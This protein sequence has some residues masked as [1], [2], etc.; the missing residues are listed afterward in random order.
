MEK[1]SLNPHLG[2]IAYAGG[3]YAYDRNLS[4]RT[5][6][7]LRTRRIEREI[8]EKIVRLRKSAFLSAAKTKEEI[9][10]FL[11]RKNSGKSDNSILFENKFLIKHVSSSEKAQKKMVGHFNKQFGDNQIVTNENMRFFVEE[12]QYYYFQDGNFFNLPNE[13]DPRACEVGILGLP[14]AT[15][16]ASLGTDA[17]PR[18]LRTYSRSW[19]W[20][21]V[22]RD[23]VYQEVSLSGELPEVFCQ[24][25]N[26][27]DF[28]DLDFRGKTVQ[29][30]FADI[31]DALQRCFF[32]NQVV[33]L[34]FGGDHAVTYPL[35]RAFLK[36]EPRL[37][38]L[39]LDAH[40]DLFYAKKVMFNH[41]TPISNLMM[42]T[43]LE[44]VL[45]FGLRTFTG[46]RAAILKKALERDDLARRMRL[47]SITT[48]KQMIMKPETLRAE[49]GRYAG[50]PFFLT[51]DL[52]VLSAN[53]IGAQL[54]TPFGVGLEWHE[55]FYFLKIA[56]EELNI[57][58]CDI[59]EYNPA[60][61]GHVPQAEYFLN[62]LIMLIIDQLAK[63]NP[64]P[65]AMRT[66]EEPEPL[67][68]AR[69]A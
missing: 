17:A 52:D 7:P 16:F 61:G 1:F 15:V 5:H 44:R 63:G 20:F 6:G 50:R 25:V 18:L 19:N 68:E 42:G 10:Q 24:G 65:T 38:L 55:L 27:V 34:F 57:V 46:G 41:A 60:R 3:F 66:G 62:A 2:V 31:E 54:S 69:D 14:L 67:K 64:K 8:F 9:Q 12:E 33:P 26:L 45:S 13:I 39:H 49:L 47:Y 36:R 28:G 37:N 59:V 56:F 48:L 4:S 51:I 30:V 35:L 53:A 58:G 22:Y 32:Q 23:G 29:A 21:D 43:E 40:N 11:E